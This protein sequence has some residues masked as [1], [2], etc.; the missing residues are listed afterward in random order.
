MRGLWFHLLESV[1][2]ATIFNFLSVIAKKVDKVQH[3]C[4][5]DVE[6]AGLTIH[7]CVLKHGFSLQKDVPLSSDKISADA[8]ILKE[9]LCVSRSELIEVKDLNGWELHRKP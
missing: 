8:K 3:K 4:G 7:V 6:T 5:K 1:N 9:S 2:K